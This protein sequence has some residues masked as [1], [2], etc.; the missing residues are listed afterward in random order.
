MHISWKYNRNKLEL[1][2]HDIQ[3]DISNRWRE[4]KIAINFFKIAFNDLNE[5]YSF[6][7]FKIYYSIRISS[8]SGIIRAINLSKKQYAKRH[9][10]ESNDNCRSLSRYRQWDTIA[11]AILTRYSYSVDNFHGS[12]LIRNN[13]YFIANQRLVLQNIF[14]DMT[15]FFIIV[16]C[17]LIFN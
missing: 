10:W 11:I 4:G 13:E 3:Y 12:N 8:R 15:F 1:T 17:F 6:Y 7:P 9:R 5:K 2:Q 14:C 16:V